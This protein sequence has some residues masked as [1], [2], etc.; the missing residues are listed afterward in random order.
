MVKEVLI[1][2]DSQTIRHE[3]AEALKQAGFG[4]VEAGDGVSGL[5]RAGERP[6]VMIIL[7]VNMPRMNGLDMLDHLRL[8]PKTADTPVVLL[9]TEAENAMMDRA[10]K[11][12]A[13]GWLIKPVP[14]A[15]IVST[16]RA[17]T[18]RD[19]A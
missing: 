17:L 10:R 13:K 4:V 2:D 11:A 6:F 18:R 5:E 19:E 8:D 12:G 15:H 7:D 14:M 1:V 3:I 9:T 16:V